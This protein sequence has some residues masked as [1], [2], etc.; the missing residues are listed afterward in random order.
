VKVLSDTL[1][2]SLQFDAGARLR[3]PEEH[4][5][6]ALYPVQGHLTLDGLPLP[7]ATMAVLDP[8][9]RRCCARKRPRP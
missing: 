9:A 6:R 2:V 1:Y 8:A 4:A 5:E 3:L 7:N